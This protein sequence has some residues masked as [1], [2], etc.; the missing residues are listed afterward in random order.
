MTIYL[1]LAKIVARIW[2]AA[3]LIIAGGSVFAAVENW[4]IIVPRQ[5]SGQ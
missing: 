5:V 4:G 1:N 2:L 3:P